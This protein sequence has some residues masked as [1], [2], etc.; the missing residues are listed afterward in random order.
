MRSH[1]PV[2]S[3][4][5][6]WGVFVIGLLATGCGRSADRGAEPQRSNVPSPWA[7]NATTQALLAK[8]DQAL[9]ASVKLD[10]SRPRDTPLDRSAVH[11]AYAAACEAGAPRGC[12]MASQVVDP[13]HP[14]MVDQQRFVDRVRQHCDAGHML[15]CRWLIDGVWHARRRAPRT[16]DATR[17]PV[18]E[19]CAQADLRY[20]C[21]MG[22]SE[23]CRPSENSEVA[24]AALE[25]KTY[26]RWRDGCRAGLLGDCA[27]VANMQPNGLDGQD[28]EIVFAR[29]LRCKVTLKDCPRLAAMFFAAAPDKARDALERGCQLGT[30]YYQ[31]IACAELSAGYT[32]TGSDKLKE[33]VP[34]RSDALVAWLRTHPDPRTIRRK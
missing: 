19:A 10:A 16:L 25:A 17:C 32:R 29:D 28:A 33:L 15:S 30:G 12:W 8:A 22:F 31:Y 13:A 24:Y 26:A 18:G 4:R 14:D 21:D 5:L 27:S 20:E 34:G 7:D 3:R 2:A 9:D 23:S 11:A 6:W 1:S